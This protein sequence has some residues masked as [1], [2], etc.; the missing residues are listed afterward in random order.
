MAQLTGMGFPEIRCKRALMATGN[1][2]DA[3]AAMEWLFAHMEDAG[4]LLRLC[5][6]VALVRLTAR[7]LQ[8]LTIPYRPLGLHPQLTGRRRSRSQ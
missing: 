2:G 8:T 5:R 6:I 4:A 7:A 1:S 3:N